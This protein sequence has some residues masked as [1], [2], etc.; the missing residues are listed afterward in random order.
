MITKEQEAALRELCEDTHLLWRPEEAERLTAPFGFKCRISH[1]K[2]DASPWNPKGLTLS[3]GK[4][5]AEGASSWAISGQI[6][7]HYKLRPEGKLGRGS[8][9]CE[10]C[11]AIREYLNDKT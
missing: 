6:A 4:T 3:A 8:Q 11:R 2:A 5:E 10:D 9:V 7:S 1:Y